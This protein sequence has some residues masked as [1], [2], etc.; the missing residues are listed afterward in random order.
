MFPV[1]AFSSN[2]VVWSSNTLETVALQAEAGLVAATAAGLTAAGA[3]AAAIEA[4]SLAASA[5]ALATANQAT[6]TLHDVRITHA[7]QIR[8]AT[9]RVQHVPEASMAAA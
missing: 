7:R 8:S 3:T 4:N 5:T 6:V 1:A 2:S 9:Q